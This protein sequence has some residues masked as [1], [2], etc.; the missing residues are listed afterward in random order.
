MRK[1]LTPPV[2]GFFT[3]TENAPVRGELRGKQLV[4]VCANKFTMEIVNKPE[5]LSLVAMKA[6]AK[7][8]FQVSV[9]VSDKNGVSSSNA[10]ME[11]LLSFGRN[12]EG[13]VNI[14]NN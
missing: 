7:L 14:K 3:T 2:V 13:I 9:I 1:E 5:I 11:Q 4:L 12:H 10:H 6:S 8:G